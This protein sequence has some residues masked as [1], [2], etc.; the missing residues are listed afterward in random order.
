MPGSGVVWPTSMGYRPTTG[1][2]YEIVKLQNTYA[3]LL[4]VVST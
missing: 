1:V 3:M 4:L 2:E